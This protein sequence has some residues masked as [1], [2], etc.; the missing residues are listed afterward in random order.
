M[1]RRD[2]TSGLADP[3]AHGRRNE[4]QASPIGSEHR[5]GAISVVPE[6]DAIVAVCLEG[7]FDL[8]N[9]QAL[10]EQ[11]DRALGSG[12]GVIVDLSEATFVDSS[13]IH[14]LVRG[15]KAARAREQVLVVQLGTAATVERVFEL[16]G[17]EQLVPRAH[18]RQEA[19]RTIQ[20]EAGAV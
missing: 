3:S 14:V 19:V 2:R 15:A 5:D 13:V 16:A 8:T 11:L 17:I 12:N 1:P 9:A 18:D 6:T 20:L 7:D 10:G 4:V